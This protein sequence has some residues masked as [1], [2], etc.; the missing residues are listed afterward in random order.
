MARRLHCLRDMKAIDGQTVTLKFS[1]DEITH[2]TVVRAVVGGSSIHD[3]TFPPD[4]KR[5]GFSSP[6]KRAPM[7]A[8]MRRELES[9]GVVQ[10]E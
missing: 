9:M 7:R 4:H 2:Q 10:D 5:D 8:E 3:M 1:V 6:A